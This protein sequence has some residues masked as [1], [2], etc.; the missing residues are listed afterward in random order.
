MTMKLLDYLK[1]DLI[2]PVLDVSTKQEALEHITG[3]LRE[4]GFI[5]TSDY[6]EVLNSILERE[7]VMSTGIG[8]G[9]AIP[10]AK[11]ERIDT[12]LIAFAKLKNELDFE[13]LDHQPVQ[14]IFYLIGPSELANL[15]VKAL[16]RIARLIKTQS[17]IENLNDTDS[18]AG[19]VSIIKRE[20]EKLP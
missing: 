5:K 18:V 9:I 16:A 4:K 3:L 15:Y 10:H 7:R 14:L 12:L 17:L 20:D 2:I 8:K 13:S 6:D 1:E 11:F 19:I